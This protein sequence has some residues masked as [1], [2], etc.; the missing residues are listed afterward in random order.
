M[1]LRTCLRESEMSD[2]LRSGRWPLACGSA[3]RAHVEQCEVCRATALIAE[4]L[5]QDRSAA[6][7]AMPRATPGLLWWRAQIVQRQAAIR[8]ASQPVR[9]AVALAL[10]SSLAVVIAIVLRLRSQ[11]ADWISSIAVLP[12]STPPDSAWSQFAI[13]TPLVLISIAFAVI[14]SIGGVAMY[15]VVH[16]E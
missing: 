16:R 12:T 14:A 5:K 10:A 6:M 11:L 3:L 9:Y 2:A 8:R 13:W 1:R 15:A 4:F 7:E